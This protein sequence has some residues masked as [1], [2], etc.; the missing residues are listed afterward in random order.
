MARSIIKNDANGGFQ[1]TRKKKQSYPENNLGKS[2]F[3]DFKG[4]LKMVLKSKFPRLKKKLFSVT[5][6][7]HVFFIK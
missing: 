5:L 7:V 3:Y 2:M 6:M 1:S 4:L